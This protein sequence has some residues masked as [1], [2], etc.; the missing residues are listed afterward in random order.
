M[1][2]ILKRKKKRY[3]CTYVKKNNHN[4]YKGNVVVVLAHN[5]VGARVALCEQYGIPAVTIKSSMYT[6]EYTHE[7]IVSIRLAETNTY[8]GGSLDDNFSDD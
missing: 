6:Y 3:I 2:K 5:D 7:G 8:E 1:P 4:Q